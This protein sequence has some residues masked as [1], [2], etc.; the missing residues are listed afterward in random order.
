M[1]EDAECVVNHLVGIAGVV[2][3]VFLREV[4]EEVSLGQV[5][6]KATKLRLSLRSKGQVGVA[7]IAE[8]IRRRRLLERADARWMSWSRSR[9]SLF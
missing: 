2:C 3:A 5:R 4:Q 1:P 6:R 9:R 8:G 7:T